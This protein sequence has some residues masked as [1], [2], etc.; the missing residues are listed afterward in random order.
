MSD[1]KEPPFAF[2]DKRYATELESVEAAYQH[3][4]DNLA[5]LL[6]PSWPEGAKQILESF[7]ELTSMRN[8]LR[9][10][11]NIMPSTFPEGQREPIAHT[12][13]GDDQ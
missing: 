2:G 4:L 11:V 8:R 5:G 7:V 10:G 1:D 3:C 13:Q 6:Q 12:T 9:D